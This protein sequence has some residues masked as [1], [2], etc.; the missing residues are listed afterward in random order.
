[1]PKVVNPK[2]NNNQMPAQFKK[3]LRADCE[4]FLKGIRREMVLDLANLS[5]HSCE[6]FR[7]RYLIFD[8]KIDD[9]SILQL[10]E[11]LRRFWSGDDQ[12]HASRPEFFRLG[13]LHSW[14]NQA[15]QSSQMI[16]SVGTYADGT[17][18]LEPNYFPPLLA[19]AKAAS[20]LSSKMGICA[21]AECPQKYFLKGRKTQRFCDRPAC[22]AY[23]QRQHKLKWWDAH[24]NKL[25]SRS[26]KAKKRSTKNR[27][28]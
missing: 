7:K 9:S 27:R 16:W 6:R 2:L 19:V 24:K 20:E 12:Y 23:G 1:M 3:M 25:R 11:Q 22:A 26:T 21:N 5:D 13:L 17:H 8:P 14:L 10:R 18:S 4:R 15:L 28:T